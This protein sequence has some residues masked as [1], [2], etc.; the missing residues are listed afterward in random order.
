NPQNASVQT[1]VLE[2]QSAWSDRQLISDAVSRLR[3]ITGDDSTGW[4]LHEAR[5]MLV[6]DPTEQSAAAV[7]NLLSNENQ[8]DDTDPVSQLVLADAMS[9]LGDARAAADHLERAIDAGIDSPALVLRLISIR[10]SM[11]E[12]DNARRRALALTQYEPVCDQIRRERVA[13][14]IRLGL[15]E[16]ARADADKLANSSNPRDLIIAAALSGKLGETSA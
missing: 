4:R 15:Y 7:V 3:S 11:G 9:I 10:Q 8:S 14:M 2:S 1:L 16:P 6:F 13:A 5:R 12:I